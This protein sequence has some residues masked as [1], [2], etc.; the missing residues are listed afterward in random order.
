MIY[1]SLVIRAQHNTIVHIRNFIIRR[2][3]LLKFKIPCL[4]SHKK[5]YS[6]Y[7]KRNPIKSTFENYHFN[8]STFQ[9]RIIVTGFL[10]NYKY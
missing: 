1:C 2:C 9:H 8:K 10:L 6:K 5:I 4:K 7:D 3:Q